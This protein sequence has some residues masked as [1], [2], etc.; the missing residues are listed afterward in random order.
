MKFK[1]TFSV[2]L[3]T[4]VFGFTACNTEEIASPQSEST[5]IETVTSTASNVTAKIGN[6]SEVPGWASQNGSTTGGDPLQKQLL[7]L[8]HN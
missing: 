4:L 7:L 2:F 8:M 5:A 1:S 3:L 6:C